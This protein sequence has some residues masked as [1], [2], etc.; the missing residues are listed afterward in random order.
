MGNQ[1]IFIHRNELPAG[2]TIL[3]ADAQKPFHGF[4]LQI[5]KAQ[6][7]F[8]GLYFFVD[9]KAGHMGKAAVKAQE[10]APLLEVRNVEAV[11]VKVNQTGEVLRIFKEGEEQLAFAVLCVGK[12]LNHPPFILPVK[13]A[14]DQV[15]S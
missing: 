7:F 5:L 3:P 4:L 12:P 15:E 1:I 9:I 6:K 11:P 14:S 10:G 8:K 2:K 13:D